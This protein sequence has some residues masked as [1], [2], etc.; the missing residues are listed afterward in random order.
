MKTLTHR[1]STTI[2]TALAGILA[3]GVAS[4][5]FAQPNGPVTAAAKAEARRDYKSAEAKF[6]IGDYKGA[7]RQYEAAEAVVP[8][9]QTKYKIAVCHDKLL[10]VAD[11]ARWYQVFLD[12]VPADKAE[13]LADS[14]ADA[15]ARLSALKNAPGQVRLVVSPPSARLTVSVDGS[16]PIAVGAG[17][18]GVPALSLPPGHHRL[19]LQADG[20]DPV[21]AELDVGP[22]DAKDVRLTL[23]TSRPGVVATL[24]PPVGAPPPVV[25]PPIA[26]PP[27]IPPPH[28]RSNIPAYVLLGAAGAGIVVGTSFGVI[29][30]KDKSNF[31]QHPTTNGADT[32]HTHAL[33]SDVSFG[34]ATALGV[35]G[36][37]LLLTNL[38]P[39]QPATTGRTF[40]TPYGGPT[41][42]GL[43]GGLSF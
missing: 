29:A 13:K 16:A 11:A 34:V 20:Y 26:A 3:L 1:R 25:G 41:G 40:L 33:I 43:V 7:L 36:L 38:G 21:A 2:A 24:P 30:L 4:P 8:V 42:G 37:V 9:P 28:R 14:M 15:R 5:A 39:S 18:Q 31:N 35:T 19:V 27:P 23:N 12:S 17:P 10:H 22:A 32:T 6:A